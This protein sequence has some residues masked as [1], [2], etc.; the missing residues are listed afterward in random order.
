LKKMTDLR[1]FKRKLF[2]TPDPLGKHRYYNRTICCVYRTDVLRREGLSFLMYRD[3]GLTSGKKLYFELIDRGYKTVELPSSFLVKYV[4]HL[5]HATQATNPEEFTLRR[6]T[7]RKY[8][9]LIDKIMLSDVTKEILA[10]ANL[11]K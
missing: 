2:R 8:N 1:T 5:A 7:V 10:D 4:V 9:R 6:K 3:K 11:D